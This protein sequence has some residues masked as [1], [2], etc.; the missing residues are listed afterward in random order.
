[1][2]YF[3]ANGC[4]GTFYPMN[5][6]INYHNGGVSDSLSAT[7]KIIAKMHRSGLGA[8]TSGTSNKALCKKVIAPKIKKSI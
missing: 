8:D 4:Q 5:G 3:G 2:H 1:M 7:G 6:S